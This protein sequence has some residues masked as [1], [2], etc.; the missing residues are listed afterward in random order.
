MVAY[1]AVD[2]I[3]LAIYGRYS[4]KKYWA[5]WQSHMNLNAAL[6]LELVLTF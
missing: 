1:S 3:E 5:E 4:L 2:C 6:V